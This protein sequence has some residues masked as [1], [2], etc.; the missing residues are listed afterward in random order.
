M[1]ELLEQLD[2]KVF[3]KV[4]VLFG[5]YSAEREISL[6][7]G[8]AVL[9]ALQESGVDAHG[10]DPQDGLVR[11][12]QEGGFDRAF[13]VLH[14]RGGEDGTVQGLLEFMGIP[15]TGSGVLGSA[16]AMD[17]LRTKQV[18]RA[19][20][21]PTADWMVL[22]TENLD[23]AVERLGLPMILK[24]A[25]EGS[26]LGMSKVETR[27]QLGDAF[28]AAVKL[29][30]VVIAEPWLS[31]PEYTAAILGERVLPMIRMETP[32]T[33]YD[34]EA[35]YF[36][37]T[38][39]YHIPCGL[40]ERDEKRFGEICR[41]AFGLVGAN[42]WGRVDFMLDENGEP[43]VLEVN[44]VPGMTDHSLVPMAAA[45]VGIDFTGLCWRILAD[46]LPEGALA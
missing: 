12:L 7:S 34:Y 45:A 1:S 2:P 4:A 43:Q 20:G 28:A 26:S 29:D 16:L 33:F 19:A 32:N 14:G 41:N 15:Y 9:K 21:V 38:T 3:G 22:S 40:S 24:P 11:Q 25:R 39:Q 46:T 8:A 5:G 35:K 10:V 44:T 30:D 37:D 27:E 42:A 18:L 31:G 13:I 36:S 23:E 17:K 6:K